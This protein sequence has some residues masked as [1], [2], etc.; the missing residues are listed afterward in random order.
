MRRCFVAEVE[1]LDVQ[2][3][4]LPAPNEGHSLDY[5]LVLGDDPIAG[6]AGFAVTAPAPDPGDAVERQPTVRD[7]LANDEL[8]ALR[9]HR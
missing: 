4:R 3:D 2:S 5:E 6:I 9:V 7:L 8:K 1:A